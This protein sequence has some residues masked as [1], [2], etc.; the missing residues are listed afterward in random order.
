MAVGHL[1]GIGGMKKYVLSKGQYN[2]ADALG[3][4]LSDYYEK[5]LA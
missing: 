5:F 1:G 2:P 3:T 4:S